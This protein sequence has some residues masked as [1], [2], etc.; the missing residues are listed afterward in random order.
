MAS[1]IFVRQ[2]IEYLYLYRD[3]NRIAVVI[4]DI[5]FHIMCQLCSVEETIK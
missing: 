4:S 5:A 2:F 3:E 1:K